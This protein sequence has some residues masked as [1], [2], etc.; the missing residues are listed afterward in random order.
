M[1][2]FD[3]NS[4][5]L[6]AANLMQTNQSRTLAM[7]ALNSGL[8]AFV[9]KKYDS[10]ISNLR[11]AASLYPQSDVAKNALEYMARSHL[12]QGD[13][14]KAAKAYNESLRMDASQSNIRLAL[15]N[16][17]YADERYEEAV[18]EYEKAVK[19]DP[20]ATNIYSLAQ[21]YLKVGRYAE[22]EQ[23]FAQV[24]QLTPREP[25]ADVGIG[26]ARAKQ[27]RNEEA[28][29][30]FKN[31]ID[32]QRDYWNAYSEMG[33]TLTDTGQIDEA[34][35][36]LSTLEKN[37]TSLASYL[38]QYIYEKAPPVML[39]AT[40]SDIF[41]PFTTSDGPGTKLADMDPNLATPGSTGNFA[42]VFSFNKPMDRTSVQDVSNWSIGRSVGSSLID[43]YNFGYP[44]PN[45]EIS[46]PEK[47]AYVLYDET[48]RMATV[49]FKLTQ[50]ADGNG[51]VDPS[52]IQFSFNGEDILGIAMD[53]DAN[54]YTGFSGFA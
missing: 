5:T 16:L 8:E 14:D 48:Y 28:I 26:Q 18:V 2:I 9:A 1:S 53:E 37:D 25:E 6:F 21:G 22:A 24:K 42:L 52:H 20:S 7:R 44:T 27:G 33:Y 19:L 46:L 12:A 39:A 36:V 45:T 51:T 15:G 11:R 3:V 30:S 38:D 49:V 43:R 29:K 40:T 31:A 10:A 17:H 41:T 47:P 35:E 54:D 23:K 4:S 50:N 13:S 34:R 32:I